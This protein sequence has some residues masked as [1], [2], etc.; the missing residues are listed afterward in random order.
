M[1]APFI[2][3]E[4][5]DG[6]GKTTQL[7]G[8]AER[9]R[10]RGLAVRE[11]RAP[12]GAPGAETIRNLL[13]DGPV[14]AFTP[15]GEALMMYAARAE[16]LARTINPARAAGEI[17]LCDRFADSTDAYQGAGGGLDDATLAQLRAVVV[18]DHEPDLTLI[19]DAPAAQGLARA[20]ARGGDARFEEK[21]LEYQERVR[22]AFLAIA[23][24]SPAS[25]RIID[26]TGS[27]AQVGERVDAAVAAVVD[28]WRAA[29]D[30]S[31]PS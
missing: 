2:V 15:L 30:A 27:V 14:D 19:F 16:H 6:T 1:R 21:G 28:A 12:G 11:T 23:R 18:G 8:L 7:R 9:L 31:S 20:G 4:G 24:A 3:F 17:V 22:A 26:A 10:A 25:R 5:G 13:V 29:R